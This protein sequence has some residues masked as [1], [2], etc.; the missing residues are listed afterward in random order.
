MRTPGGRRRR[1]A[2]SLS[3]S[4]RE[5]LMPSTLLAWAA[6]MPSAVSIAASTSL[7][8]PI[9]RQRRVEHLAQPVQ[10]DRLL[11]LAE[12]AAV[13]ALVVGRTRRDARER[14]AGHDDQLAA[15]LLDRGHLLFVAGDDLIDRLDVLQHQVIGAAARG[16]Q[17]A[18][19]V[20][21]RVERTPDQLQRGRPVQPHAALRR[22]HGLGDTQAERPE[23]APVGDRGVP[24]DRGTASQGST[25]A[26][27]IRHHMGGGVGDAVELDVLGAA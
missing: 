27:G 22:V 7:R 10:D 4:S 26:S 25:A 20:L 17:R 24:V 6:M 16:D 21:G 3:L 19:H 14:A 2:I 8:S 18:R 11:R 1:M 5:I 23:V 12:D 13:D 9:A 15:Q